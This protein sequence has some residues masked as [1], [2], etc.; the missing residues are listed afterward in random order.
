MAGWQRECIIWQGQVVRVYYLSPARGGGRRRLRDRRVVKK[1]LGGQTGAGTLSFHT[2]LLGVEG[3]VV[4]EGKASRVFTYRT[5]A[6]FHYWQEVEE[7]AGKGRSRRGRR[8]LCKDREDVIHRVSLPEQRQ[9]KETEAKYQAEGEAKTEGDRGQA[10][11]PVQVRG[12][13]PGGRQQ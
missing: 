12:Q 3:E 7:G 11:V 6:V 13:A 8:S 9:D 1:L 5:A 4:R 10:P 2:R